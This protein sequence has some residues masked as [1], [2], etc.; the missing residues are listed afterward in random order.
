MPKHEF[1]KSIPLH[2][3]GLNYGVNIYELE[4]HVG[5]KGWNTNWSMK[6]GFVKKTSLASF[7]NCT[8]KIT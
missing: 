8:L 3:Q 1:P 6:L 2:G 7:F 4:D 5:E